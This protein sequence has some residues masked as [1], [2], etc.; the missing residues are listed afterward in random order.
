MN[1]KGFTI[2]E[3]L[4]ATTV[5]SVILLMVSIMMVNMGNLY[6]KGISQAHAQDTVRD[7][8]D[9]IAQ[10]LK[11]SGAVPHTNLSLD[12]Q[13][14]ITCIGDTSYMYTVGRQI[15]SGP[16]QSRH[17]LW[18]DTVA[19]GVCPTPPNNILNSASW[20]TAPATAAGTE[21]IGPRSRLSDFS[22]GTTTPYLVT[23][24]IAVGDDDQLCSSRVPPAS[25]TCANPNASLTAAEIAAGGLRC[26]GIGSDSFCAT[27]S[28]TTTAVR[29][30][31]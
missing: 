21:L 1:Q 15:G 2:I 23:V 3:L 28:L 7:V 18:R 22:I 17:V 29:R 9:E 27:A 13:T 25:S 30:L 19:P 24:A 14:A 5:V 11:L 26:K 6:Y 20:P 10:H 31:Y 12:G 16:T 8:T 4:I